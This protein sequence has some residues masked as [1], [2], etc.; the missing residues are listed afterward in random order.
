MSS[1]G[2]SIVKTNSL[3]KPKPEPNKESSVVSGSIDLSDLMVRI[4]KVSFSYE[5][6][7]KGKNILEDINMSFPRS[8]M[9]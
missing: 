9:Y 2:Q 7:I 1:S 8:T 5:R 3:V 4:R 6:F